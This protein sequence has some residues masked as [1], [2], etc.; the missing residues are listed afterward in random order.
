MLCSEEDSCE[1]FTNFYQNTRFH[2]PADVI[3]HILLLLLFVFCKALAISRVL[4]TK[5]VVAQLL[6]KFLA[7]Y[8]A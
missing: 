7:F 2:I 5:L 3:L 1:I 4:L 8:V 6:N